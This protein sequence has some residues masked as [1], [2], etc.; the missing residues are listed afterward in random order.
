MI[1]KQPSLNDLKSPSD[2]NAS[3]AMWYDNIVK[4]KP[5][6]VLGTTYSGFADV[7][8]IAAAHVEG[9]KKAEA[10]GER[11]I[12]CQGI[13]ILRLCFMRDACLTR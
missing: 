11:I 12:V 4:Q 9:L 10:S 5:D 8:D 13:S 1:P 7:R 6:A 3:L 2:L